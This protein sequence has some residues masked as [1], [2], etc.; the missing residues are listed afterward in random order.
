MMPPPQNPAGVSGPGPLSKRTDGGPAQ[1]LR[2]LPD[3]KYGENSQFQS[4]QQGAPLSA[5]GPSGGNPGMGPGELPPNPAAGQVVPFNADSSRPNEPVTA[6]ASMGPGPGLSA[7]GGTPAQVG[8]QNMGK[9][10]QALPFFE[11]MA[12]MQD[13]EPST[14]LLVNLIRGSQ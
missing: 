12:N 7:L 4:L 9:I 3:A 11:M 10:S 2:D 13:A 14:R 6:G 5:S 1:A 8:Q